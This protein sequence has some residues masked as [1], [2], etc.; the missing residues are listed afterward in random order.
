VTQVAPIRSPAYDTAAGTPRKSAPRHF[1]S[2]H[3]KALL[4][5]NLVYFGVGALAAAYAFAD[6]P[7][8]SE[9]TQVAA[10]AFSPAGSLGPLVQAYLGGELLRAI[11]LTFLVN[12]ILGSLVVLTLPSAVVPFAGILLG[13]CR[14]VLWGLLVSP[15]EASALGPTILLQVP[16]I[17]IEGEAY[18]VAMLGVW[19]WWQVVIASPGERWK[20]WRHGV[21]VQIGMYRYVAALL[22][23]AATYEAIEVIWLLP[24]VAPG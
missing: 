2:K 16:T 4:V 15:T 6:P 10:G 18:V 3:L 24:V 21:T 5:L 1:T 22:A 14:A 11:V 9:L 12:L 7:L 8:Q 20:A 23:A 17:L 19:L 13:V